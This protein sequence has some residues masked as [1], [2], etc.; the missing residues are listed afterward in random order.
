[1]K[2][3]AHRNTT[4]SVGSKVRSTARIVKADRCR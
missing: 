3:S 1:M 2:V 4:P